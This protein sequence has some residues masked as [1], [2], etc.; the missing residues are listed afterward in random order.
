MARNTYVKTASGWEQVAST[1]LAVPQGLV[2]VVPTSVTNGSFTGDGQVSFSAQT[3]V[4]LNG[5]FDGTFSN[6]LVLF[7]MST[8]AA[9]TAVS[10]RYRASG[11]D[12]SSAA[13]YLMS[14]LGS[15]TGGTAANI[16]TTGTSG[17]FTYSPSG[18]PYTSAEIVVMNP[19]LAVQ[20]KAHIRSSGSDSAYAG[21]T[22]RSGTIGHTQATAYDGIT[23]ITSAAITGTIRVYGYSKGGLTQPA[24]IQPYSTAANTLTITP[25][26]NTVTSATVTFPAGRFTQAPIVL[27][28]PATTVPGTQVMATSAGGVT[29]SGF[30]FYL[31]RTNTT[32][33]QV[34]W[35]ATQ[36]TSTSAGG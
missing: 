18:Y 19:A 16:L 24:Q 4:S 17:T 22:A 27:T 35:Q 8:A 11:T 28:G 25:V 2:P 26:A 6:Y 30:T 13:S 14:L 1:V 10:F 3:S 20:T 21:F 5:V 33:T 7:D 31:L 36:M 12:N 9:S 15:T 29:T 23:F 34:Y 32:N